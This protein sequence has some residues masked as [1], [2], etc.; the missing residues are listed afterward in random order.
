MITEVFVTI[1]LTICLSVRLL[2]SDI[3]KRTKLDHD[4]YFTDGQHED[5]IVFF[6]FKFIA[7]VERSHRCKALNDTGKIGSRLLL[8]TGSKLGNGKRAFDL[9]RNQLL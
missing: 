9:H 5:A 6:P 4:D 3:S 8:I 2:H 1:D 7:K